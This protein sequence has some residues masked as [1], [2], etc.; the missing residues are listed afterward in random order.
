VERGLF[1]GPAPYGYRYAKDGSGILIVAAEAMIVRRIFAEYVAGRSLTAIAQGLEQ[2]HVRTKKGV[3]WRQSTVS[4]IVRN[5]VY[6][7]KVKNKS[8]VFEGVHEA[9]VDEELWQRAEQ[10]IAAMPAKRGRPPKQKRHIFTGGFLRCGRCGDAMCPR[11]RRNY[12]FYECNGRIH[13]CKTGAVRRTDIDSGV[14]AHFE[15]TV[16]DVEATREQIAAAM[17]RKLVEAEALLAD[18]EAEAKAAQARLA[19]INRDYSHGELGAADWQHFR[20]ELEPE[21]EAAEAE[22]ERLRA[23]VAAAQSGAV[24]DDAE[25]EVTEQLAQLRAAIAGD[26]NAAEGVEAVRAVLRRLFERFIFHPEPPGQAH[27]ELIGE[28]YW[29]EPVVNELAIGGYDEKMRPVLVKK[30]L[31]QAANK[32]GQ[33]SGWL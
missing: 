21:A 5:P 4:G 10:L 2:D 8:E 9:I 14:L 7:G 23:Q 19:K 24:L 27:V 22:A 26:V 29:I 3:L 25:A 16:L 13:G 17:D 15:Q 33:G 6:V 32:Y 12:E 20:S 11:T 1:S 31:E 30:P 18:A 28:R